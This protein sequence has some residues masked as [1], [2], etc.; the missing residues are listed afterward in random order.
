MSWAHR[1]V[2]DSQRIRTKSPKDDKRE[3]IANDPLA[4]A[5]EDHQKATEEEESAL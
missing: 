2:G 4:N 3:G 5:T 1:E